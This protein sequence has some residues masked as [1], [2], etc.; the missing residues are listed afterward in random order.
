MVQCPV[1]LLLNGV[2]VFTDTGSEQTHV[3]ECMAFW[4]SALHL[5]SQGSVEKLVS[6]KIVKKIVQGWVDSAS[7]KDRY[8]PYVGAV[9]FLG[10]LGFFGGGLTHTGI[11]PEKKSQVW[12]W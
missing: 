11:S 7:L 12:S 6:R 10:F 5:W 9:L 8:C 2:T 3:R 4:S 1:G